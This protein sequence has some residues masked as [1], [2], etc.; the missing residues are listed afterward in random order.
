MHEMTLQFLDGNQK[1]IN[2]FNEHENE[3]I[4]LRQF[5]HS[6]P[7]LSRKEFLTSNKINELLTS[8]GITTDRSLLE[9][10]VIGLIKK[11]NSTKRIALRADIDA[12]PI[13][14]TNDFEYK[15]K[16]AGIMHACGHDGHLTMLLFAAKYLQEEA[17]FDGEVLLVFQ[18]DEEDTAGARD[19]INAG[20]FQKYPVD[21]VYGI[22]NYPGEN[23][24]KILINDGP[25]MAGTVGIEIDIHGIGCHA[26]HPY[27]GIDPI[28]ITAQV[29]LA[30]Q[31][32]PSRNIAA[33]DSVVI[34][35]GTINGGT[36]NNIIPETIK[37]TGT[38]RYFD[39]AI[40]DLTKKRIT[41]ITHNICSAFGG[42]A[43]VCLNDGYIATVNHSKEAEIA[44]KAA[45]K[46]FKAEDIITT[47]AP[48]MGAEDF[49]FMLA[50]QK[51]AYL[52]IG[53]GADSSTNKLHNSG[54]DFDDKNLIPGGM[55][56]AGLAQY[57]LDNIEN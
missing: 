3:F 30:L 47:K 24:G 13:D 50:D 18:P 38:L 17:D 23:V 34:T 15:S 48:S 42:H 35:I 26:A 6:T 32:I 12:L 56:W 11:G 39:P 4:K 8:W 5:F 27:R 45:Q 29:I 7:E 33:T 53:N 55:F 37:L 36:A 16:N 21:A 31:S 2:W 43:D 19:L 52:F 14:E 40:R 51:G 9:T 20:L 46:I 10:A 22:H 1:M 57:F 49:G 25:Q 54:F 41:E 44:L 28:V